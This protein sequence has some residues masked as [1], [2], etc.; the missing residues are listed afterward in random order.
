MEVADLLNGARADLGDVLFRDRAHPA[1]PADPGPAR[2][3]LLGVR[4]QAGHFLVPAD[5]DALAAHTLR[6]YNRLRPVKVRALRQGLATAF[7]LGLGR[8]LSTRHTLAAPPGHESLLDH[9]AA[10]LD[11]PELRFAG[12]ARVLEGFVTPVLQ[13][14][15]PTGA[16]LGFAKVGWDDV[17]RGIVDNEADA[18][19]RA[20]RAGLGSVRVPAVAWHGAWHDLA[21]L[22][23]APMP[24]AVKRLAHR[25]PVPLT[26][27]HEIA[28]IDGPM[29]YQPLRTSGYWHDAA[30]TVSESAI[31]GRTTVADRFEQLD[32]RHG[33]VVL[34]F[35]R[36]HGDWVPWNLARVGRTLHAWDWAYSAPAVPF[37]F[38]ALH[39]SFLPAHVQQG[40]SR[41][42]ASARAGRVL[43]TALASIG[44]D[45]EQQHAVVQLHRFE[46]DLR[47]ERAW[48]VRHPHSAADVQVAP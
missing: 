33:D 6:A 12:T 7:G 48:L 34:G 21:V 8:H 19:H 29:R 38:D 11:E 23:T 13:L 32:A 36:G 16:C 46:Q 40:M 20:A 15:T 1:D 9:L 17:T 28:T 37:G 35:G 18:L 10:E 3:E 31:A 5:A 24:A 14:F 39:F 43:G 30:R 26:P 45:A 2:Y 42:A 27:L 47:D 22:V 41:D 25:A 44:L 4:G